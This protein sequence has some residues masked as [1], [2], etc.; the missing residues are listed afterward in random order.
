MYKIK[1][2]MC[3][4]ITDLLIKTK[5]FL[6]PD[7][8]TLSVIVIILKVSMV[9]EMGGASSDDA[10]RRATRFLVSRQLVAFDVVYG[11]Y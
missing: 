1:L 11:Q 3:E 4:T 7:L 6:Y 10:I 2:Y 5:C 8:Q 9:A